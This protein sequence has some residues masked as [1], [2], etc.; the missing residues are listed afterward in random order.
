VP[1]NR[2]RPD[3]DQGPST[4]AGARRPHDSSATIHA[5]TSASTCRY[6][7]ATASKEYQSRNQ[8]RKGLTAWVDEI[9]GIIPNIPIQ[10]CIPRPPPYRIPAHPSPD[11]QLIIPR[12]VVAQVRQLAIEFP[13]RELVS[14]A[15]RAR[16]LV[17][18]VAEAAVVDV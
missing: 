8:K 13:R 4:K 15:V 6:D 3:R 9:C 18:D 5:P 11:V 12:P 7:D 10:I 14:I 17:R 2:C 16:T 1:I